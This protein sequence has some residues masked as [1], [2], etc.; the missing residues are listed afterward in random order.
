M[1][2]HFQSV[3]GATVWVPRVLGVGLIAYS[4]FTNYEWGVVK[5]FPMGYHLVVDFVAAVLDARWLQKR[6]AEPS[7]PASA[8]WLRCLKDRRPSPTA[9]YL[10][11]TS[12]KPP[13]ATPARREG[14]SL[15]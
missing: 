5:V 4:F 1:L 12:Q 10:S 6:H 7:W 14:A 13:S 9:S 3:G 2:F 11:S 8:A 15:T